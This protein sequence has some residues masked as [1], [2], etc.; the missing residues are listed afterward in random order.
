[1]LSHHIHPHASGHN[2]P[3]AID[4]IDLAVLSSTIQNSTMTA[5]VICYNCTAWSSGSSIDTTSNTQPW[6]WAVGPGEPL[7]SASQSVTFN[8]HASYGR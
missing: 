1:M 6:I 3:E 4:N 5:N 8:Q 7:V 2:T